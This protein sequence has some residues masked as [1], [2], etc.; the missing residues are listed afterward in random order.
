MESQAIEAGFRPL[1]RPFGGEGRGRPGLLRS[2]MQVVVPAEGDGQP[3][4]LTLSPY[5]LK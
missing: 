1:P 3:L 4:T 5:A 2:R